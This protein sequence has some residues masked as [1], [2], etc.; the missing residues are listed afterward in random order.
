MHAALKRPGLALVTFIGLSTSQDL[1]LRRE[2]KGVGRS[3]LV[4]AGRVPDEDTQGMGPS[5]I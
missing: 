1:A 4:S 2:P 3:E 5:T